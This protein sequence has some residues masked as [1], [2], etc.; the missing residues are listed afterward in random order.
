MIKLQS[1]NLTN[2]SRLIS[3]AAVVFS[4]IPLVL[5]SGA[6]KRFITIRFPSGIKIEA[7]VADT[8]EKRSLG[9]MFRKHLDPDHGMI[10][11]FPEADYHR[12]WMKNCFFE[13]DIIW[14][15]EKKRI[16]YHE[17]NLPPCRE[18]PCPS[19]GPST[20]ALYVI[21][22]VGGFFKRIGLKNGMKVEFMPTNS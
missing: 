5:A 10:F 2:K 15:D 7:E 12:F 16:V 4:L 9:L 3:K 14:L 8:P 20:K 13:M 17:K 1:P 18:D 11:I 22:A 6:D 19:Y 21:E